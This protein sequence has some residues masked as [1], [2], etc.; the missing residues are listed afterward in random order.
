MYKIIWESPHLMGAR[1]ILHDHHPPE[2]FMIRNSKADFLD[3]LRMEAW[4]WASFGTKG[5]TVVSNCLEVSHIVH[6]W[7][8]LFLLVEGDRSAFEK[9]FKARP[10]NDH[11]N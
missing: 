3:H 4:T 10:A 2:V 5:L 9:Y 6:R 1:G 7:K 8:Q 11:Y